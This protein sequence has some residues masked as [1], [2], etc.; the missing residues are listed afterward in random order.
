MA[1]L[2]LM[3][4]D[5]RMIEKPAS[6]AEIGVVEGPGAAE[7]WVIHPPPAPTGRVGVHLFRVHQG[8]PCRGS[9]VKH[10]FPTSGQEP[11]TGMVLHFWSSREAVDRMDVSVAGV[12]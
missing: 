4:T 6:G 2:M 11:I 12:W 9:G 7:R 1:G 8:A 10:R 5:P 3:I